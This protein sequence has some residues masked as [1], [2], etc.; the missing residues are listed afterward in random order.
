MKKTLKAL[1]SLSSITLLAGCNS[2]NL[3][4]SAEQVRRNID[5]LMEDG[6]EIEFNA[7]GMEGDEEQ[8]GSFHFGQK[9]NI[10]WIINNTV[11]EQEEFEGAAIRIEEESFREYKY[12][13]ETNTYLFVEEHTEMENVN[14]VKEVVYT[15]FTYANTVSGLLKEAGKDEVAGRSVTK[16]EFAYNGFLSFFGASADIYIYVDDETGMTVK[17]THSLDADVLEEKGEFNFEITKLVTE[18]VIAPTLIDPV[19]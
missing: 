16:Y 13:L 12:D 17:A 4:Y 19:E 10:Y 9:G 11:E 8:A 18:G 14:K 2:A 15:C 3:K 7:T 6:V 1:V 5:K